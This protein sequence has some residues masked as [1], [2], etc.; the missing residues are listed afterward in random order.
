MKT[1]EFVTR[2]DTDYFIIYNIF[3]VQS[4]L[5][6]AVIK[7]FN[8]I[9]SQSNNV[10]C[11]EIWV[12]QSTFEETTNETIS[13]ITDLTWPRRVKCSNEI[14]TEDFVVMEQW[15]LSILKE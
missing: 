5:G 11:I 1:Q 6:N 10:I 14:N 2:L 3:V 8:Q 4:Q 15:T 13:K 9:A 12:K 7:H